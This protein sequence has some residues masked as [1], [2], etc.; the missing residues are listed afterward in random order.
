V[1]S[2]SR[3]SIIRQ[4]A[5]PGLYRVGVTLRLT[6]LNPHFSESA[7][8]QYPTPSAAAAAAAAAA[9]DSRQRHIHSRHQQRYAARVSLAV[10]LLLRETLDRGEQIPSRTI[11]HG[12]EIANTEAATGLW[13]V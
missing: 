1:E 12:R 13:R 9:A 10:S 2:V 11:Q 4:W 6:R 7:G 8:C 5:P 3:H